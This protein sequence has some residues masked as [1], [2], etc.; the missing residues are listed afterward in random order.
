MTEAYRKRRE[1]ERERERE[2]YV[3]RTEDKRKEEGKGWGQREHEIY[4][5][6]YEIPCSKSCCLNTIQSTC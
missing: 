4:T 2:K 1:R 6:I 3:M 5:N